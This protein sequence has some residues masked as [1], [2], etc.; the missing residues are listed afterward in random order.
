MQHAYVFIATDLCFI[1]LFLIRFQVVYISENELRVLKSAH[2][3]SPIGK[4]ALTN[5]IILNLHLKTLANL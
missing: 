3:S 1:Q 2:L 4:A 5:I